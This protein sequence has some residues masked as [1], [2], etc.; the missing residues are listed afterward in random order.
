[1]TRR[2]GG[3][4]SS[5]D[6]PTLARTWSR[7][8]PGR[9][10]RRP[11]H[12]PG[13]HRSLLRARGRVQLRLGP[14]DEAVR[15][16]AGTLR[17]RIPPMVVHGFRNARDTDL[18]FLNLH[19]PGWGSPTTCARFAT[20][21]PAAYDQFDPPEAGTRPTSEVAISAQ[22]ADE[23]AIKLQDG[24]L[25]PAISRCRAST[26][27]TSS[28]TSSRARW[29]SA[30]EGEERP[31]EPGTWVH[32]EPQLPHRLEAVDEPV[33]YLVVHTPAPRSGL[34]GER[35]A[36]LPADL[37]HR[38]RSVPTESASGRSGDSSSPAAMHR[39]TSAA[40]KYSASWAIRGSLVGQ[41]RARRRR[42]SGRRR[43]AGRTGPASVSVARVPAIAPVVGVSLNTVVC[44]TAWFRAASVR[45]I[46]DL[47][48]DP[49]R[50]RLAG[51]QRP[52][53]CAQHPGRERDRVG[54]R[55]RASGR[56]PGPRAG[57]GA[58]RRSARR[59]RPA[60]CGS[61][62][63]PR[64]PG[65]A[66]STSNFGRNNVQSASMQN[67]P[68]PAAS[69]AMLARLGGVQCQRLLH[70][71]VLA[72]L[73]RQPGAGEVRGVRGGDVDDVD[74][75]V[76]DELLV[77]AVG[78][79]MPKPAAKAAERG[80]GRGSPPRRPAGAVWR[81]TEPTNRSAIQP[82][83]DDAPAQRRRRHRIGGCGGGQ[84]DGERRACAQPR[85]PATATDARRRRAWRP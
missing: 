63:A 30:A 28:S 17:P 68:A 69:S 85:R 52:A 73:E 82:V 48:V 8:G 84:G 61:R 57:S 10:G 2:T 1:M 36:A 55:G 22:W 79:S 44:S 71:H 72:R 77:A 74:V 5:T 38:R 45:I 40:S 9:D 7:F 16:P 54:A 83:P 37:V 49:R 24:A 19:A 27:A 18:R 78:A 51:G 76:G 34:A 66:G 64:R 35:D 12:P 21:S 46:D 67:T 80:R 43:R 15:G 33:R 56:R 65:S 53:R 59:G 47:A 14:E 50:V 39:A 20:A 3:W 70:Q 23:P 32:V 11:A 13:A 75:R 6:H 26:S 81:C 41:L 62:R 42:R 4:R 29:G 60:R 58:R 25:E 31:L